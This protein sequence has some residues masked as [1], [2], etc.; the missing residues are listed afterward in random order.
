MHV[1]K[2]PSSIP[3]IAPYVITLTHR[4]FIH[5]QPA[6]LPG[7]VLCQFTSYSTCKT[8]LVEVV[9]VGYLFAYFYY[10]NFI[11]VFNNLLDLILLNLNIQN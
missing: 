11:L 10:E 4:R 1:L 2:Y 6:D 8:H 3:L 9:H 7:S 5:Q